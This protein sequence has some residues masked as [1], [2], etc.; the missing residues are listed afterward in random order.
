MVEIGDKGALLQH[1]RLHQHSRA[2]DGVAVQHRLQIG[3]LFH[4]KIGKTTR[5]LFVDHSIRRVNKIR[6]RLPR[7]FQLSLQL[8]RVP[9]VICIQQRDKL[10]AALAQRD[11]SAFRRA[12]IALAVNRDDPRILGCK[13]LDLLCSF[14]C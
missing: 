9:Y 8:L 6:V 10:A 1:L 11:I 7:S 14:V 5:S 2:A 13:S 4:D 3:G 12:V